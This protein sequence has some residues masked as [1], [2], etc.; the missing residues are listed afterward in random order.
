M[1][2][3]TRK[4]EITFALEYQSFEHQKETLVSQKSLIPIDLLTREESQDSLEST[5]TMQIDTLHEQVEYHAVNFAFITKQQQKYDHETHTVSYRNFRRASKFAS[6]VEMSYSL[7]LYLFGCDHQ[8][9]SL[10]SHISLSLFF[11]F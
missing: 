3:N 5:K 11:S 1:L 2:H 4:F 7:I 9:P 10:V 6:Q 8:R